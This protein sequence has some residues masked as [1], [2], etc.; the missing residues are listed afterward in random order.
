MTQKDEKE[1]FAWMD[2][3]E[4]DDVGEIELCQEEAA[5]AAAWERIR[6][7]TFSQLGMEIVGE[8][9]L[10]EAKSRR[11]PGRRRWIAAVCAILIL[12]TA[13]ISLSPGALAE[14]QKVLQFIPGFGFV[15]PSEDSEHIAYVLPKPIDS[16]G[17]YGRITVEGVLIEPSVSQI[18]LGGNHA[19]ATEVKNLVLMTEQGE[20]EFK[21]GSAAWGGNGPWQA[22]YYYEGNIPDNGLG[23]VSIRFGNTLIGSIPLSKA[24]TA[25]ELEG[26]GSS[27]SKNGITVTGIL[28]PLDGGTTKINLLTQLSGRQKV[29][30]YGKSSIAE[31]LQLKLTDDQGR[32]LEL[33]EEKGFIKPGELLFDDSIG[34]KYYQVVIPAIRVIDPDAKPVKVTLPV[35]K[36]GKK[37][38]NVASQIMGFTIDFRSIE[39]VDSESVRVEVDTHFDPEQPRTLQHY[40]LYGKRGQSAMSYSSELN[41]V[42]GAITE[43]LTVKP[44]QKEITFYIGE[45][46]FVVKGSWVLSDMR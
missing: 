37:E 4:L 1:I 19:S 6:K 38:I 23:I 24:A 32:E 41:E 13:F 35:P 39:R 14:M 34:S 20:Y 28:T 5:D 42:T 17:E 31:G 11:N 40:R 3:Q 44:G 30:S 36:E 43:W 46:Q 29:D 27:D 9:R 21:R 15:Q 10:T 22:T 12:G 33:K 7:R 25:E 16:I 8:K 45:P 2:H 26:F 18:S